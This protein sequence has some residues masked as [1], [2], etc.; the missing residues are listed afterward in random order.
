MNQ[1]DFTGLPITGAINSARN[2]A[3]TA[4]DAARDAQRQAASNQSDIQLLQKVASQQDQNATQT[5]TDLADEVNARKAADTGLQ[6]QIDTHTQQIQTNADGVAKN[7]ADIAGVDAHLKSTDGVVVDNSHRLTAVEGKVTSNATDIATNKQAIT[8]EATARQAADAGL[9]TQVTDNK[10][11]ADNKF[12]IINDASVQRA[13][14]VDGKL[15][16]EATARQ[17][18]DAGLQTQV[19]DNKAAQEQG[20]AA[21]QTQVTDNKANADA[22]FKIINDASVQRARVV[23][24]K[25]ADE[26]TARQTADA[27]LQTQVTDNKAA[28]EQGDAALQTQ[29]TDNKANADAKFKIVNDAATQRARIVDGKL[30][31]ETTAR[32]AA[33]AG[34]QTQ[35]TDNKAA[36]DNKFKIVND[37]AAQR[38]R[39]VDA[40]LNTKVDTKTFA[41]DQTRQDTALASHETRIASNADGIKSLDTQ[42]NREHRTA[43]SRAAAQANVDADHDTR[44]THNTSA[45]ATETQ[46]R[47]SQFTTLSAGVKQAQDTGAYA[48]KRADDAYAH[49][50]ANRQALNATNKRVAD[51][52]A[53]IANHEQRIS[54]LESENSANFGKLKS[55]V[56]QNRKR[57]SAGIAGVAA[58]ANIPQVIQGQ[59]FSVGAGMGNTDGESALAVGMSARASEHVV[60]KASVSNDT[61]HN[62]VV[63]AGVSYGW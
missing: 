32:Q 34:L 12:K 41:D 25:L 38:A 42:L 28:Q 21:L 52:T 59:T 54:A 44:I 29:V 23:D 17:T 33:D 36:A 7:A 26:A 9:Q 5:A 27:G 56:D 13:R 11:D 20:D 57:A 62:F 51:N 58:M 50:E 43:E 3:L 4:T 60:V 16:D 1:G 14:I 55:E 48:Q 40:A 24:G 45:I 37:A 39:V 19:T 10:A 47:Q 31:D 22:K 46:Q 8:D 53:T 49:T 15:A 18:A 2:Q 35:V 6:S 61:Q 63:G 30:A